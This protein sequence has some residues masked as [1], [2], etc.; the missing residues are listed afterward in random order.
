MTVKDEIIRMMKRKNG[1]TVPEVIEKT[2][3]NERYIKGVL[4]SMSDSM[5]YRKCGATKTERAAY[6]VG[7]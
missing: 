6:S 5:K 1:A 4:Y 3:A 7:I 2:G